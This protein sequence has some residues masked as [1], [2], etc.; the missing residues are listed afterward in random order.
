MKWIAVFL[1]FLLLGC[2]KLNLY[3]DMKIS[4][5]DNISDHG[6]RNICYNNLAVKRMNSGICMKIENDESYRK[7]CLGITNQKP[8]SEEFNSSIK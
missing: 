7:W 4:E 1:L 3:S 2:S 6:E 5:C 8:V